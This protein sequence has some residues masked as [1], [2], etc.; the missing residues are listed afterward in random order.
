MYTKSN[1]MKTIGNAVANVLVVS[2]I[3]VISPWLVYKRYQ[4]QKQMVLD[5][6]L[7]QHDSVLLALLI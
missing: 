3:V 5:V 1:T 7:G 4:V 6:L 2:T